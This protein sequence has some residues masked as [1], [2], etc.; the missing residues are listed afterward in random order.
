MKFTNKF[1][2][3]KAAKGKDKRTLYKYL[4]EQGIPTKVLTN[5]EERQGAGIYK[6]PAFNLTNNNASINSIKK[7]IAAEKQRQE[8]YKD[9][10]KIEQYEGL[11][12]VQNVEANRLQLLFDEIPSEEAR[13]V[14]R[15]VGFKWSRRNQVWQRQLTD[16]AV[17]ALKRILKEIINKKVK[18]TVRPTVESYVSRLDELE[19]L[20]NNAWYWTSYRPRVRAKQWMEQTKEQLKQDIETLQNSEKEFDVE[21]YVNRYLKF[22]SETLSARSNCMN[23]MITGPAKFPYQKALRSQDRLRAKLD[24]FY[25]WRGKMLKRARGKLTD[26]IRRGEA[27]T[28]ELLEQKLATLELN[29][30]FMKKVNKILNSKSISDKAAALKEE[31]IDPS[32]IQELGLNYKGKQATFYLAPNSTKIRELKKSIEAEKKRQ[33]K[34]K[35]GNKTINYQGL[36]VVHNVEANRL[37]LFFETVPSKEVRIFLKTKGGYRWAHKNKAWQRQLTTNAIVSL[38]RI[39][40]DILPK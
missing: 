15:R 38:E 5:I 36:K 31:G 33:E 11:Q 25:A 28:I 34:Y 10:N 22:C 21:R 30:E 23:S 4:S 17:S 8:Q 19:Q 7:R 9:G 3:S 26:N 20:A 16:N 14:L 39:L 13:V 40:K 24:A 27:N 32:I 1:L 2:R 35:N 29:H 6:I 37:Q 12:V 18:T